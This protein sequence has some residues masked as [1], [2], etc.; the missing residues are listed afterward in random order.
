MYYKKHQKFKRE[1]EACEANDDPG[2]VQMNETR[3]KAAYKI[4]ADLK[5]VTFNKN[6]MDSCKLKFFYLQLLLFL[7]FLWITTY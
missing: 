4:Y 1:K 3:E 6:I 5:N 2:G 7:L